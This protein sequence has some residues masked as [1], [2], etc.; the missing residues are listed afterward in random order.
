MF[1]LQSHVPAAVCLFLETWRVS[2][3]FK[4]PHGS[5]EAALQKDVH[6]HTDVISHHIHLHSIHL[7]LDSVNSSRSEWKW[8]YNSNCEMNV[9]R[10]VRF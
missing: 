7:P 6:I 10:Y 3:V 1:V 2:E 4:E 9:K 5:L 8:K